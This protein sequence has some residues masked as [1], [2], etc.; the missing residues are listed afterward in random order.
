M[1][2]N[3]TYREI[4]TTIRGDASLQPNKRLTGFQLFN[5]LVLDIF[6]IKFTHKKLC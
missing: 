4:D 3:I 6:K 1:T 2:N 5:S